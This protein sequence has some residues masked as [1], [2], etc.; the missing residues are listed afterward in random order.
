MQPKVIANDIDSALVNSSEDIERLDRPTAVTTGRTWAGPPAK[1]RVSDPQHSLLFPMSSGFV[2][3]KISLNIQRSQRDPR[4]N[5]LHDKNST[6]V[7]YG[8]SEYGSEISRNSGLGP[9]RSVVKVTEQKPRYGVS[10]GA[11]GVADAVSTRRNGYPTKHKL[12]SYPPPNSSN[13]DSQLRSGS[14]MS[15]SWKNSEE[16][17]FSWDSMDSRST[18]HDATINMSSI[19]KKDHWTTDGSE[20]LVSL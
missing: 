16:E 15:S 2:T 3:G 20:K 5:P 8:D 10:S 17:E 1:M 9:G 7:V 12:Q 14:G 6:G 13:I 11:V 19:T 4:F 18:D